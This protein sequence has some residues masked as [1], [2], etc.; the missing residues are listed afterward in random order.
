[1]TDSA[2]RTLETALALL[3]SDAPA[4]YFRILTELDGLAIALRV[5]D[6]PFAVRGTSRGLQL[7]HGT[8]AGAA[9]PIELQTSRRTIVALIDGELSLLDAVLARELALRAEV[10]VLDRIARAGRAFAEG[11]LRSRRMRALLDEFRAPLTA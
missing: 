2:C 4:A 9:P 7:E 1:V 11:A 3:Q 5:D 10:R 6:E 8:P